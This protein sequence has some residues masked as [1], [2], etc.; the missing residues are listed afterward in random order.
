MSRFIRC[1]LLFGLL[2]PL[3]ACDTLGYYRQGIGGQVAIW[4]ARQ[5]IG[6]AL[7]NP[8][9]TAIQRTRLEEVERIRQ[10]AGSQLFMP[11][12]HQYDTYAD[13]GRH[14]VAWAVMAAPAYSLI[15]H[16][17]CYPLVGCL[18][19]HGF[20]NEDRARRY[21]GALKQQGM[22]IYVAPVQAY[23]TLGWFHDSVLNSFLAMSEADLAQLI[24]HELAHQKLFFRGDT[25]FNESFANAVA[26]EGL[27]R[28]AATWQ[29][30][31]QPWEAQQRVERQVMQ[32][33]M[34]TR[35]QL[36]AVY[37]TE[38]SM[39]SLQAAK[40]AVLVQLHQTFQQMAQQDPLLRSY[41]RLIQVTN[42]ASLASVADYHD[43]VPDFQA[44][45]RRDQGNLQQFF[46]DCASLQRLHPAARRTALHQLA[47]SPTPVKS[48]QP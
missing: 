5:P 2:L 30:D 19:Y 11:T 1:W 25:A 27:K 45:L 8:G 40:S 22:D 34:A 12:R 6:K 35:G 14:Y 46:V 20:F 38:A 23:S 16:Q 29:L 41:S 37:H 44:L 28:Y 9:L 24:F 3:V 42:N 10:F 48:A 26:E 17:W 36:Q 21:A 18:D 4:R 43:L 39:Q 33:L 7:Q 32:L 13:L 31:L 47:F 15:P